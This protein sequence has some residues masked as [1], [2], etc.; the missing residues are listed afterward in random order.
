[1][2]RLVDD[3]GVRTFVLDYLND[4]IPEVERGQNEASAWRNLL[5]RL[6]EF[7]RENNTVIITAVQLNKEG[8]AYQIG[9]ALQQKAMMLLKLVPK[10]L[11]HVLH[12]EYDGVDYQY[13]PG[14]FSP[15]VR[16]KVEKYRGG[17]RGSF[18]LLF[19]GPRYLWVDMP[20]GFDDGK[21]DPGAFEP[22]WSAD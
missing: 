13:V 6:E 8:N 16:V 22:H 3:F 7:N 15:R 17:G 5:A 20:P 18:E 12:F 14:D 11:E 19:V 21:D 9:R 10:P 2:Q 4:I 1:M